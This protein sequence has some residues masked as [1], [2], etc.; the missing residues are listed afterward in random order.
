MFE[1][2]IPHRRTVAILRMLYKIGYNP[3]HP[4]YSALPLPYVPVRVTRCVLVAHRYSDALPRCRTSQ[5]RRTFIP[6]SVSLW[7]DHCWHC[8]RWCG[9]GGFQE[10]GHCLFIGLSCPISFLSSAFFRFHFFLSIGW[11]CRA[12]V[13]GLIWCTSRSPNLAL[14]TSFN[15]NKN[16][17]NNKKK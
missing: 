5:Y 15:N 4:L 10:Q 9:T 3:M 8:I 11:Y 12:D 6:S 2:D 1:C 13:Y 16:N 14:Q 7:N 17:N